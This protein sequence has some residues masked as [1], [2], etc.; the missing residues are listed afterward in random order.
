M[1]AKLSA[2][3]TS[4]D[5][6]GHHRPGVLRGTPVRGETWRRPCL[7]GTMPARV[8]PRRRKPGK[9]CAHLA[10]ARPVQVDP[11]SHQ[12]C[13]HAGHA[14]GKLWVCLT[15]GWVSCP[16]SAQAPP[17]FGH[18]SETD[19]PIAAPL[20]GPPGARWCFIDARWV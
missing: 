15:C 4:F 7:R 11:S 5:A 10:E 20:A 14:E 6:I 9:P 3:M 13:L 1:I 19:H 2:S 17:G 16:G 12:D 8:R 18:Y